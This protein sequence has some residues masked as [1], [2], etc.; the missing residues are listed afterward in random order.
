MS[1][2]RK[3]TLKVT[4]IQR[5]CMHDGPGIRT[6]VF[7]KGCPL[8][9][10][11][12]HNPETPRAESELLFD[13]KRCIG[14]GMCLDVCHNDVHRRRTTHE[15]IRSRC[16]GCGTCIDVCPTG[17]LQL[18]GKEM[19]P[20]EIL[21]VVE[22]DLAFYGASGGITLSGGEPFFQMEGAITLLQLCK[23]RGISTAVETCGCFDASLLA[24]AVP[25]TDLFLWDLKDTNSDRHTRYTGASNKHILKNLALADS[26]GARIRLRCILVS[27]VNTSPEHYRQ[28]ALIASSLSHLDGVELIPYHAYGGSKATLLGLTD[29]GH[30][31]WIPTDGQ[32]AQAKEMLCEHGISV[33]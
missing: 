8:R 32:M 31:E 10:A 7:F 26:L 9:C 16:Q 21:C 13:S 6:T 14:C 20:Q 12:C 15:I 11:W 5:F 19:T 3:N 30:K 23:E 4:E 17:A 18:C 24:K 25:F 2:N 29:N 28:I 1:I 33:I 22:K 27:G